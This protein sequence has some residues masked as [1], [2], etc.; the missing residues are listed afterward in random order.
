MPE[1]NGSNRCLFGGRRDSNGCMGI[2]FNDGIAIPLLEGLFH[3][4]E[5]ATYGSKS[6]R[7]SL[8]ENFSK[9]F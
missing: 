9:R 6:L 8:E 7:F 3:I 5:E 1:G 2:D 4:T